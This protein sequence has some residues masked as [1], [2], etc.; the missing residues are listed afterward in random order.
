MISYAKFKELFNSLFGEYEIVL[1]NEECYML[2]NY[3]E[4]VTLYHE[5]TDNKDEQELEFKN[6]DEVCIEN[7]KLEEIWPFISDII[8][9]GTFSILEEFE[10]IIEKY[11]LPLEI[12][13]ES[14]EIC[15]VCGT[16]LIGFIE[17]MCCGLK[18]PK[19][20]EAK[21]VT[22]YFSVLSQDDTIYKI[23]L[24]PNNDFD[25]N[26]IKTV[27]HAA[28][29][30]YVQAKKILLNGGVVIEGEARNIHKI[31]LEFMLENIKFVITPDYPHK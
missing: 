18:C 5:F 30:N 15:D 31:I 14:S 10:Y 23:T 26:D 1:V 9:N 17:G 3:E 27:A 29:C 6:I 19:C 7:I 25:I 13:D 12:D 28:N 22:S 21:V 8:V 16:K 4:R 2:T 11:N 24:L 20:K